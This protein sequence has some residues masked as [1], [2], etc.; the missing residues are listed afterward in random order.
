LN[1]LDGRQTRRPPSRKHSHL[2]AK[3]G[4]VEQFGWCVIRGDAAKAAAATRKASYGIS[5]SLL[6]SP[7]GLPMAS[8]SLDLPVGVFDAIL[9]H[10]VSVFAAVARQ[11]T[12]RN[13]VTR[14]LSD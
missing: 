6:A 4:S 7:V 10:A 13:G 3:Y 5:W 1:P 2:R 8:L 12:M 11:Q 14:S 9:V